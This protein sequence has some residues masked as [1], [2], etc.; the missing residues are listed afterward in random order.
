[1]KKAAALYRRLSRHHASAPG[2]PGSLESD[3]VLRAL[4]AA[5]P[6]GGPEF[7]DWVAS[8]AGRRVLERIVA[9]TGEAGPRAEKRPLS[10]RQFLVAAGVLAAVVVAVIGVAF[11]LGG[12]QNGVVQSTT[13]VVADAVDR[14]DALTQLVAYRQ[15]V[16]GGVE[17]PTDLGDS[18][19]A[20][21]QLARML[22]IVLPEE[23][24]WAATAGPVRRGE[25]ALWVWRAFSARLPGP[26]GANVVDIDA[27][28][29]EVRKAVLGVTGAGILETT[30]SGAFEPDRSLTAAEAQRALE[31]LRRLLGL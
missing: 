24:A 8:E 18:A 26:D 20:T 12:Q 22:G 31:R 13:T 14:G 19:A 21:A 5:D 29:D 16:G 7:D 28:P 9:R 23:E 30:S 17:L 10:S 6:A 11:G 2:E 15:A 3:P 25:F 27:V 1:M 4:K